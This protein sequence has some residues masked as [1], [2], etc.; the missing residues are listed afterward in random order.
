MD[1]PPKPSTPRSLAAL[2][3]AAGASFTGPARADVSSWLALT[4]GAS[5]IEWRGSPQTD[6]GTFSLETGMGSPP[7]GSVIVGGLLRSQTHLSR[8]TDLGLLVRTATHG[9]VNGEWGAALDLGPYQ[10]WWGREHTGWS[11]ALVLGAPWGLVLSLG[12]GLGDAD[13]ETYAA[14]LGVDLARLTVYRRSGRSWWE[15]PFPAYRPEEVGA[16][17]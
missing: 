13:S 10:R 9:F 15:N 1:A 14:T 6:Q 11:G 2:V 8:G 17:P 3:V 16:V 4:G 12:A 7:A 5:S